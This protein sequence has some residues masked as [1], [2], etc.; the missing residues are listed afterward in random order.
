LHSLEL[1]QLD[2]VLDEL[3]NEAETHAAA[4]LS[5]PPRIASLF[6]PIELDRSRLQLPSTSGRRSSPRWM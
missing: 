6:K 1:V 4:A 5:V 3:W 2:T